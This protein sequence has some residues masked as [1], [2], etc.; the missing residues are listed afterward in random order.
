M[1]ARYEPA[2]RH[3]TL[4]EAFFDRVEPARFPETHLR[5]RNRRWARRVGLDDLSDDAWVDHFARFRPLPN[6]LREPLALRYHGHQFQ[7][8]NPELGDGRG[9]LFAQMRE[10]GTDR[11][12][13]LATKGSGRTPWSR[14]ADG[15]LTLKGG[16]REVLAAAMLEALG[17]YTSKAF[18]LIETGEQLMRHDEPSPTRSAVLV[19]LGHGHIRIGTF[20]RLAFLGE[21]E[22]LERLLNYAVET[23]WPEADAPELSQRAVR[24]LD[25]VV[26]AVARLGAQWTA[27]GFVHGVINTDNVMI[28]GESFD[29]GP[30]RFAPR[31]DPA[32]TAAYFD[33]GGL[34]AFGNQPAALNWSLFRL[35][36]CLAPLTG[37]DA[38][39]Q[40]LNGFQDRFNR[41]LADATL[42]RLG[43]TA[44][45][46]EHADALVGAYY[47]ALQATDVAFERAFFDLIGSAQPARLAASPHAA[48]YES[49]HWEPVI[50]ALRAQPTAPGLDTALT[51]PYFRRGEPETLLID[52]VEGIWT[53]IAEEDDWESFRHCLDRIDE[54]RDAYL[55]LLGEPK[56]IE[57]FGES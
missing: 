43:L 28:T 57:V 52:D 3:Q 12:L 17:V 18:S 25:C 19:R 14:T 20:Q 24:F 48:A 21:R 13:D 49:Q 27:A 2:P 42:A 39:L 34:Y 51:H 23:Y 6:N 7:Q 45:S 55:P 26:G 53:P 35:A 29:Y 9:F 36:D 46:A 32:F 37:E 4:G 10:P 15:R 47:G 41:H 22:N 1:N 56:R 40:T 31:F 11:L 8:Y 16:V 33:H 50:H 5:Y 54:M 30:W 38:L 44:P